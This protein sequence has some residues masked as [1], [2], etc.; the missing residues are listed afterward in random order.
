MIDTHCHLN[1]EPL[2]NTPSKFLDQALAAGVTN[3]IIP[4]VDLP[5]SQSAIDLAGTSDRLFAMVG[6]HPE[7]AAKTDFSNLFENLKSLALKPKV[8]AIGECGLDYFHTTQTKAAQHQL[9]EF[10]LQLAHE[11][12]LPLS[13]HVRDLPAEAS[14]K[15]DAHQDALELIRQFTPRAVLHCFSGNQ[16]YLQAALDLGL[17]ISFAGNVTFQNAHKLQQL[18]KLTPTDRLLVETDA[19]YLN[20]DRGVFP[21]T[22]AQ[23]VKTYHFLAKLKNISLEQ[24]SQAVEDNVHQL[25]NV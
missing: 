18:A 22:P 16:D 15:E 23:V 10:Q 12:D 13:I 19:P 11:L 6:I 5:T 1:L 24:L 14:A 7:E 25:F 4:A 3:I 17:F 8:V 2:S 9:F 20:P 21:N